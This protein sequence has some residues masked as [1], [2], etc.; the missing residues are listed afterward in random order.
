MS[1]EVII[2]VVEQQPAIWDIGSEQYKYRV[3]RKK[4]KKTAPRRVF[5]LIVCQDQLWRFS[6]HCAR[7]RKSAAARGIVCH[8]SKLGKQ[9]L[10]KV[11][12]SGAI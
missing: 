3:E 7:S 9:H 12:L 5:Q 6:R 8:Y 4:K 2:S 11:E 1:A 10:L